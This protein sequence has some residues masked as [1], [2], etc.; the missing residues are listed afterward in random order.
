VLFGTSAVVGDSARKYGEMS[1]LVTVYTLSNIQ[2][3]ELEV[4]TSVISVLTLGSCWKIKRAISYL[5][6][7]D[8]QC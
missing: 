3:R 1:E 8:D 4:T 2:I 7:Y 6:T 5:M